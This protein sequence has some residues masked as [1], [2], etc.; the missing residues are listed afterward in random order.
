MK[1]ARDRQFGW[2]V[3]RIILAGKWPLFRHFA[4]LPLGESKQ[5][6]SNPVTLTIIDPG[7]VKLL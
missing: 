5:D 4:L 1:V 3:L 7:P 6:A 2:P